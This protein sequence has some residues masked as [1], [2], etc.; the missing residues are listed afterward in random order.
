MKKNITGILTPAFT[1]ALVFCLF[2]AP[3]Q[4]REK[5][6]D[7]SLKVELEGS[8]G[9]SLSFTLTPDG[10]GGF[11][12]AVLNA[13]GDCDGDLDEEIRDALEALDRGG[14]RATYRWEDAD[15]TVFAR[16]RGRSLEED[17][18]DKDGG[19]LQL[20]M[21]WAMAE[22]LLGKGTTL[23]DALAAGDIDLKI[24]GEDGGSFKIRLR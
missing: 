17:M 13:E 21:P 15:K 22:C 8:S 24:A 19:E 6:D 18:D 20:V 4:A 1:L 23:E 9:S 12:D 5:D 2:S 3:T 10:E 7:R 14:R 16:R 11:L